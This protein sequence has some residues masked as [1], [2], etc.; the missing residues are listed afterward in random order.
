MDP[1]S[2]PDY[3]SKKLTTLTLY[4]KTI[5][6]TT[7]LISDYGFEFHAADGYRHLVFFPEKLPHCTGKGS[8][9]FNIL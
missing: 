5:V 9:R 3:L 2:R 8:G 4:P 1:V 6:D 7:R